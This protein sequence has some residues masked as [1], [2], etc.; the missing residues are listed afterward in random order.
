MT[1]RTT[2]VRIVAALAAA[3][4]LAPAFAAPA[5]ACEPVPPDPWFLAEL[6]ADTAALPPGLGLAFPDPADPSTLIITNTTGAPLIVLAAL[7]QPGL[8]EPAPVARTS[9]G[10]WQTWDGTRWTPGL[11][12]RQ[13][14][15]QPL[16]PDP[17]A[18]PDPR[19]A[20]L[21][22]DPLAGAVPP[23][24]IRAAYAWRHADQT[25]IVPLTVTHRLNPRYD[26]ARSQAALDNLASFDPCDRLGVLTPALLCVVIPAL[27]AV[28]A[29]VYYRWQNRSARS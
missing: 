20:R 15:S 14:I 11:D 29:I 25:V 21:A 1:L 10:F 26:A 28:G 19:T 18:V 9:G 22:G 13:A 6:S 5:A 3:L 4:S 8:P 2:A 27:L 16:Y 24:P 17:A 12:S 7:P 23:P